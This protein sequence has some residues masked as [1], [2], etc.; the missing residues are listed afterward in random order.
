[1]TARA[2]D[3]PGARV[4]VTG[5]AGFVG[6]HVLARLE[7]E[8]CDAVLA[9]T[10][11]DLDLL[12]AAALRRAL[13]RDRPDV[14]VHL[15]ARVGGIGANQRNPG[16]YWHDNLLMG[17]NVLEACRLASV[18]RLVV[19]GTVCAYPKHAPVPFR[20]SSLWDGFPEETNAPYGVAK[21]ALATGMEAYR[22]Q[23]GLS[24]AYLL[25]ANLYGPHDDFDPE[26][27]HVIP[28][29]VVKCVR[30]AEEGDDEVELWGT[31]TPTREFVYVEDVADAIVRAAGTVD[32]PSP[33]NLGSGGEISMRD[34]ANLVAKATGFRGRFRWNASRPD[35]QPRRW[36][37]T[38]E[39]ERRLGWRATT[40]LERGLAATV[41][42]FRGS[43][44]SPV[45]T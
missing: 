27:S 26:T 25:P 16:A 11:G 22:A 15:A 13:A 39:A 34:L 21:R 38:E 2:S 36:L 40:P 4:L 6:R 28:A 14:V 3:L 7:R 31:G 18:R 29:M 44:R 8:R 41:A 35:G 1:V 33:M 42:W 17:A 24:G 23:Y 20:E 5:G 10:R 30:A 45:R 9:P 32:D 19:V 12:D 43:R 37:S